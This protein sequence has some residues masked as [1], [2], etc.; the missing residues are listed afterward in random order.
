MSITESPL[1]KASANPDVSF[2]EEETSEEKTK[3]TA[4]SA[5]SIDSA[6]PGSDSVASSSS[7]L[8]PEA[9]TTSHPSLRKSVSFQTIEIKEYNIV[10]GDHP[11]VTIGPP[12]TIEWKPVSSQ[13]LTVDEYE[14]AFQGE[15]RRGQEL[16]LP[17][18]IRKSFLTGHH[19]EEE[20][21][22]ARK[23]VRKVQAQ[24][25]M[26]HAMS[27]F[28]G[29][30]G[31][32]QSAERKYKKWIKRRNGA[33]L[34]PAEVWMQQYHQKSASKNVVALRRPVSWHGGVPAAEQAPTSSGVGT[35]SLRHS[36]SALVL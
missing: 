28:D 35:R 27:D 22:R 33:E 5:S 36:T 4:S 10:L 29:M 3:S 20:I 32:L 25:N 18:S 15:R 1:S 19:S 11:S 12:I 23:Q 21:A 9:E 6:E 30:V 24:R 14:D 26:T 8:M 17:E 2:H 34:E 13:I 7:F 16:R 31:L